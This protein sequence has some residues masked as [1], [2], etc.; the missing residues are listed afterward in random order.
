MDNQSELFT[1]NSGSDSEVLSSTGLSGISRIS[2][3]K[4]SS[5]RSQNTSKVSRKSGIPTSRNRVAQVGF[6]EKTAAALIGNNPNMLVKATKHSTVVGSKAL[7]PEME[8]MHQRVAR[9]NCRVA[10]ELENRLVLTVRSNLGEIIL[11]G[12][13]YANALK[14]FRGELDKTNLSPA[15][16]EVGKYIFNLKISLLEER[17]SILTC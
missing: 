12:L 4:E 17:K 14:R 15:A 9:H 10:A 16:K 8:M 3:A 6:A 13:V 7:R 1:E 11:N 5:K 2:Q